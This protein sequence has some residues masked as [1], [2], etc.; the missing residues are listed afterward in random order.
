MADLTEQPIPDV[1]VFCPD[2]GAEPV[3]G[4]EGK[5]AVEHRLGAAGYLHDDMNFRCSDG[6]CGNKWAHGVPVGEY[7]LE[8]AD[9]LRCHSCR[10]DPAC[11]GEQFYRVHRVV[12][13]RQ[14]S[15][16]AAGSVTLHLKC[17]R[18]FLFARAPRDMDNRGVSLVGYPDITGSVENEDVTPYGWTDD[19]FE[20][21]ETKEGVTDAE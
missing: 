3:L 21:A 14:P 4:P 13:N 17:P 20:G 19:R 10:H 16:A 11:S 7:E 6:E 18:C 12:L 2:C 5:R 15:P 8:D 1:D 9:D